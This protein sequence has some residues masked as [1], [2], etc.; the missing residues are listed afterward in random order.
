MQNVRKK[1]WIIIISIVAFLGV[2]KLAEW[3]TA[4]QY[5]NYDDYVVIP[6]SYN[7]TLSDTLRNIIL[8]TEY[9]IAEIKTMVYDSV[10]GSS[11]H[12]IDISLKLKKNYLSNAR[13]Q[14]KMRHTILKKIFEIF[15]PDLYTGKMLLSYEG[16]LKGK[17]IVV[18]V[19][20]NQIKLD[21]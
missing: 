2:T 17:W 9:E 14:K 15:P 21:F 8:N 13:T 18:A 3:T 4:D 20:Y 6:T 16:L 12:Y 5:K 11:Y 19:D 1:Y 10:E 7:R